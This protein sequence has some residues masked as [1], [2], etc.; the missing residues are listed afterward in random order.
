MSD[1]NIELSEELARAIIAWDEELY[2][3]AWV[4]RTSKRMPSIL[5][6][7]QMGICA[8]NAARIAVDLD[9]QLASGELVSRMLKI[10]KAEHPCLEGAAEAE[11]FRQF[12]HTAVA[13][14]LWVSESDS[15]MYEALSATIDTYRALAESAVAEA[16]AINETT[17]EA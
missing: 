9:T 12:S 10:H 14:H 6:H 11:I 17:G 8:K 13:Y 2:G 5:K 16:D 1:F 7:A 4:R 3:I 15:E